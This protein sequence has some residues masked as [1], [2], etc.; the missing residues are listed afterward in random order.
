MVTSILRWL[1]L[2]LIGGNEWPWVARIALILGLAL[3]LLILSDQLQTG[4]E[5]HTL[6]DWLDV[7]GVPVVVVVAGGL[8]ALATQRSNQRAQVER[9]A[10][11]DRAGGEILRGFLDSMSRLIVGVDVDSG[12]LAAPKVR[13]PVPWQR[14]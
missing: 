1:R 10:E 11:A 7:F 6:W 3:M 9:E 14:H 12:L 8:F 13:L 2:V 4:F 5:D